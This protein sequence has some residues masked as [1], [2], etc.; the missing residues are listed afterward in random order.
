MPR[1]GFETMIPVFE[2][3]KTVHVLDRAA[4][5]KGQIN[6]NVKINKHNIIFSSNIEVNI[7]AM[8]GFKVLTVL[9]MN[10]AVLWHVTPC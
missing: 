9:T 5:K 3:A 6:T 8:I 4:T 2:R 1:V 7:R 10:G